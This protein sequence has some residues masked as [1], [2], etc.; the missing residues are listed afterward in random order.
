MFGAQDLLPTG[1][2]LRVVEPEAIDAELESLCRRAAE[3]AP[4]TTRATKEILR[5]MAFEGLPE[6]DDLIARVYGSNDFRQGV[7]A[8]LAKTKA[9]PTWAGQ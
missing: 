5:R 7:S 6:V 4:L 3:N 2:L 1:F 8:F 9:L